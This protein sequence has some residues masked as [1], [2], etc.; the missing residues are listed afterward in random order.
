MVGQVKSGGL[1]ESEQIKTCSFCFYYH[2]PNSG[3]CEN[4][5][6]MD[7]SLKELALSRR[8]ALQI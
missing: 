4:V 5:L 3:S 1:G 6:F 8:Q 2:A 7:I